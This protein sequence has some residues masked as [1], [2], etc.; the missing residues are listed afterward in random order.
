MNIDWET[1]EA[2]IVEICRINWIISW[3]S[4]KIWC[5][6]VLE[7]RKNVSNL[8]DNALIPSSISLAYLW[9]RVDDCNCEIKVI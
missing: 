5:K 9:K 1:S 8:V 3:P 4:C 6:D 7:I 2:T